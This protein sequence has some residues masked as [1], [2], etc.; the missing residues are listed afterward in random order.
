MR[1]GCAYAFGKFEEGIVTCHTSC[2]S[3]LLIDRCFL[4][5]D[6]YGSR[7]LSAND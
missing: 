4:G 1:L 6:S 2:S 5:G 7:N 3:E